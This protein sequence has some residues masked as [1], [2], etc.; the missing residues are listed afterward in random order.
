MFIINTK[1][2]EL[3]YSKITEL[4]HYTCKTIQGLLEP[5]AL[6]RKYNTIRKYQEYKLGF[7]LE[8][9]QLTNSS[10]KLILSCG[11]EH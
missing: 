6:Y 11:W 2:T 5:K 9:P 10:I 7:D 8:G 3:N 1:I 4:L